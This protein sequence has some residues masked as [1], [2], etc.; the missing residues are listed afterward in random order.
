MAEIRLPLQVGT[1]AFWGLLRSAAYF[2]PSTLVFLGVLVPCVW[3]FLE[4]PDML[5]DTVGKVFVVIVVALVSVP[6][7]FMRSAFKQFGYALAERP[8]DLVLRDGNRVEVIG[9]PHHGCTLDGSHC[10]IEDAELTELWVGEVK[11]ATAVRPL[12][13]ES[14]RALHE[15]LAAHSSAAHPTA[16][17]PVGEAGAALLVCG[18]C[19]APAVPDDAETVTCRFCGA[20]VA[21]PQAL[22][23]KIRAQRTLAADRPRNERMIARLLRQ[24]S[25][26]VVW[27]AMIALGVPMVLVWPACAFI[28]FR[29]YARGV[30]SATSVLALVFASVLAMV[31]LFVVMRVTLVNRQ[32]LSLVSARFS[33]LPPDKPGA[34]R[35]CRVCQAPLPDAKDQMLVRCA[36]CDADNISGLDLRA[37]AGAEAAQHRSIDGELA[38]RRSERRRWYAT[39]LATVLVIGTYRW[40]LPFAFA[41]HTDSGRCKAGEMAAC[42]REAKAIEGQ[43]MYNGDIRDA[44]DLYRR[45][46]RAHDQQSCRDAARVAS[47]WADSVFDGYTDTVP[48][49]RIG[50][51]LGDGKA[52]SFAAMRIDDKQLP[53]DYFAL[54]KRACE[55]GNAGG[56]SDHG[57][58]FQNGIGAAKDLVQ[59]LGF[60]RRACDGASRLGCSNVGFTLEQSGDLA[61]AAT[62]FERACPRDRQDR[63]DDV[64]AKTDRF[65]R[66]HPPTEHTP[67][68][69]SPPPPMP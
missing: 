10:T 14:L 44:L 53:D 6:F 7:M 11:V 26:R 54:T 34:P 13:K 4:I 57:Y 29:L 33:A 64:C 62:F 19:D 43:K 59:A 17:K 63:D 5:G 68:T 69:P 23:D 48:D 41:P 28:I 46:C 18:K 2:L 39:A 42:V 67:A 21:V 36:Y 47:S 31:A 15:T 3:M 20:S 38:R 61:A 22:R 55:L 51:E 60:Y 40:M 58:A 16:T 1:S 25:A 56:C 9:G 8:S 24:P 66:R 35:L 49:L 27:G 12:E 65:Y 30:L 52:C 45:A 50:C 32:A 37:P